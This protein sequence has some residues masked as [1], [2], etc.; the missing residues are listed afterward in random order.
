MN[1]GTPDILA[2]IL[3]HKRREVARRAAAVPVSELETR[4]AAAPDP[5]GF[6]HAI[7]HC[8][9]SGNMA[10]IAEIKKASPSQGVIREDFSPRWLAQRYA[11]A[12]AACLSV[13]TDEAF[14]QGCDGDLETAR[15][16]CGL[17]VLRKDF[18]V[19][20]YQIVEAR[21]IGADG[22]LLIVAALDDGA[23][24]ELASAAQAWGLD[25]LVEVHDVGELDRALALDIPLIGINNRNLRTFETRL[26]TTLE[27]LPR[28]PENR[29]VV[30]E[31]GIH[32]VADVQR[33]RTHGVHAFLI[34][35]T[36]MR[37]PDP[38]AKLGEL[39]GGKNRRPG[40]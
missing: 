22:V 12:G 21:S 30:T 33:M 32:D 1:T 2:R 27:L 40:G 5:R 23:L 7:Q 24:R 11:G 10:V 35:E 38:A 6:R 39:L 34:G 26:D 3:A 37:A 4:A 8:V 15:A 28:V 9:D 31:S 20:P 36:F 14:F 25:V 19:D 29:L 17:P 13:L 18:V 16:A